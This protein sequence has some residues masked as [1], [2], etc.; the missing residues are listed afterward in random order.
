MNA[1]IRDGAVDTMV[2]FLA[3]DI[4]CVANLGN[5]T[6]EFGAMAIHEQ[7]LRIYYLAV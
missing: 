1:K 6:S 2:L 7:Q 4:G 5:R 3:S